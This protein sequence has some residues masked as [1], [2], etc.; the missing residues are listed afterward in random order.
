MMPFNHRLEDSTN[1]RNRKKK[2]NHFTYRNDIGLF[3]K[4]EKELRTLKQ[5][6]SIYNKDIGIKLGSEQC[7]SRIMRSGKRQINEGIK[8]L[9]KEQIRTLGEKETYKYLGTLEADTIKQTEMKEK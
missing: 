2:I 7:A 8:L 9:N 4:N 1:L 6:I 5:T 3:A